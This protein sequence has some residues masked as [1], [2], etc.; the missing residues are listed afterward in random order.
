MSEKETTSNRKDS[1]LVK[2]VFDHL[3]KGTSVLQKPHDKPCY[4]KNFENGSIPTSYSNL[5]LLQGMSDIGCKSTFYITQDQMA[6]KGYFNL[7]KNTNAI[8]YILYKVPARYKKEDPEVINGEVKA[9]TIKTDKNGKT[10]YEKDDKGKDLTKMAFCQAAEL[11][12]KPRFKPLLDENGNQLY[13]EENVYD[14]KGAVYTEDRYGKDNKL[15][16][17]KGEPVVLH[18]A[19]SKKGDFVPSKE[20][21]TPAEPLNLP[22]FEKKENLFPLPEC[23]DKNNA[24]EVLKCGLAKAFRGIYN[25]TGES[26][27]PSKEE[28]DFL[29]KAFIQD[30]K[31]F[32]NC[33]DIADT[34]GRGNKA[35][36]EKMEENIKAKQ[37]ANQQSKEEENK[38][39]NTNTK[40]KGR[41]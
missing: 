20:R 6:Q 40:H 33:C 8:G 38:N 4:A 29:E 32:L 21:I 5:N 28:I 24:F 23:K 15:F 10:I 7:N 30:R 26:W 11:V 27:N 1:E 34:Y 31:N 39:I 25:G 14:E 22:P 16:G 36:C 3:Q 41:N 13:Y 19:G 9:G 35:I 17:K 12:V 37:L 18:F 2:K